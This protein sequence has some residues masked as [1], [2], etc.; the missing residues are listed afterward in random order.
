MRK[1]FAL[2]L[3]AGALLVAGGSTAAQ[4]AADVRVENRGGCRYVYV[5]QKQV[6]QNGICYLGPPPIEI[7]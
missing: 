2:T 3:A 6:N 7:D 4:A 5:G 1:I